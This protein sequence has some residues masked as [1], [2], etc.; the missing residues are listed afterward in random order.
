MLHCMAI[1]QPTA[2]ICALQFRA[3]IDNTGYRY[4]TSLA[5]STHGTDCTVRDHISI[6][7]TALILIHLYKLVRFVHA[8][9]TPSPTCMHHTQTHIPSHPTQVHNTTT[10]IHGCQTFT[11]N[12][13]SAFLF[14]T[15]V[16]EPLAGPTQPIWSTS[17]ICSTLT[18]IQ[19]QQR[20]VKVVKDTVSVSN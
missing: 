20:V 7:K 18:H 13:I 4:I 3:C 19:C 8:I 9:H 2:S 12:I 14:T 1:T 6:L 17:T 10:T 16:N 5:H 15:T 11:N